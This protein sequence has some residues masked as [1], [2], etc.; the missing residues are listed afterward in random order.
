[1]KK[2]V[3]MRGKHCPACCDCAE[4]EHNKAFVLFEF[5]GLVFVVILLLFW[6]FFCCWFGGWLVCFAFFFF[7][8]CLFVCFVGFFI[9]LFL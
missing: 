2:L 1:M 5:W 7:L 6:G 8:L 4:P 3:N 9:F